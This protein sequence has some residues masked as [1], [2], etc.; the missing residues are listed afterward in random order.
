MEGSCLCFYTAQGGFQAR[1]GPALAVSPQL[2]QQLWGHPRFTHFFRVL[3]LEV[4]ALKLLW[5]RPR[6]AWTAAPSHLPWPCCFCRLATASSCTTVP[7]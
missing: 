7:A 4:G 2:G 3:N 6:T 1:A 5:G